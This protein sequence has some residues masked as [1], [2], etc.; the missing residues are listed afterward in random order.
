VQIETIL[1]DQGDKLI[2]LDYESPNAMMRQQFYVD[3]FLTHVR[4]V[5]RQAY[6]HYQL[7]GPDELFF[8]VTGVSDPQKFTKGDPNENFDIIVSFDTQNNDPETQEKKLGQ[9]VQ[10]PATDRGGTGASGEASV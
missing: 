7:Y 3:K 6:K 1:I 10:F 5:L 8:R 9:L 4:D 2:G